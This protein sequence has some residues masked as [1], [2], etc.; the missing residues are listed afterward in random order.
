MQ[1]TQTIDPSAN[2]PPGVFLTS[3]SLSAL[4]ALAGARKLGVEELRKRMK[5]SSPGFGTLLSWLHHE[6]LVD[7]VSTLEGYQVRQTVV[8]TD[9]GERVLVALLEQMC[10]L[11]E[12]H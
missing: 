8:L 5:L 7:L 2:S 3:Q 10:E 9:E 11:P 1:E 4:L 12:F 6:Y